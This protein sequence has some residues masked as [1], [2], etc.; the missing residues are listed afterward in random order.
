MNRAFHAFANRS[1]S[2]SEPKTPSEHIELPQKN[3]ETPTDACSI[4]I[5]AR[6]FITIIDIESPAL[7]TKTDA[8]SPLVREDSPLQYLLS[9]S[10][11]VKH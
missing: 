3:T 8:P 10:M 6:M 7:F 9:S 2:Y 4:V 11:T 5:S 1:C